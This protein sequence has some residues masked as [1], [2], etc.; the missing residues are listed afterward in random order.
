MEQWQTSWTMNMNCRGLSM[1]VGIVENID[2]TG[3]AH[4]INV[5]IIIIIISSLSSWDLPGCV[6]QSWNDDVNDVIIVVV[7]VALL[8][9]TSYYDVVVVAVVKNILY[10]S[11][12]FCTWPPLPWSPTHQRPFARASTLRRRHYGTTYDYDDYGGTI[13]RQNWH[14]QLTNWREWGR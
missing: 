6:E 9:G 8:I 4:K 3:V 12:R 13:R 10:I 7:V 14:Q 11:A 1:K 2:M 5:I